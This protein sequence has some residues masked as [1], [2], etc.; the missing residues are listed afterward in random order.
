MPPHSPIL[1]F[2]QPFS[3]LCHDWLRHWRGTPYLHASGHRRCQRPPKGLGTNGV[4]GS[5]TTSNHA[6][7]HQAR[8]A[9]RFV[10]TAW[11]VTT[12]WF[13]TTAGFVTTACFVT[14]ERWQIVQPLYFFN[15]DISTWNFI[16]PKSS[17][18]LLTALVTA[19]EVSLV[20]QKNKTDSS[21]Y[22]SSQAV[23]SG[24]PL[25]EP[26]QNKQLAIKHVLC[27]VSRFVLAVRR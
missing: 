22:L 8:V 13:V 2:H 23:E 21:P 1:T 24:S 17:P 25:W 26:Q 20:G 6:R 10:T 18:Y 4:C 11:F 12:V 7:E 19:I 16:F 27:V 15:L 3:K 14:N 9:A 5:V